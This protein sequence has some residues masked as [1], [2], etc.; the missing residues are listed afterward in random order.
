MSKVMIYEMESESQK[1]TEVD[2]AEER[3]ARQ[4]REDRKGEREEG[5]GGRGEKRRNFPKFATKI[6]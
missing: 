4:R 2:G 5:R 3:E 6:V 1:P